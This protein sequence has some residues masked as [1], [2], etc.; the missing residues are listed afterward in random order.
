LIP[1]TV[2]EADFVIVEIAG[3]GVHSPFGVTVSIR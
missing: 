3:G 2:P 1:Y